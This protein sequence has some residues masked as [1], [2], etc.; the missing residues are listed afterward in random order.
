VTDDQRSDDRPDDSASDSPLGRTDQAMN[1]EA[2][3]DPATDPDETGQEA[4]GQAERLEGHTRR[5]TEPEEP[6]APG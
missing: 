5:A 3:P 6:S 2:V 4:A 1:A